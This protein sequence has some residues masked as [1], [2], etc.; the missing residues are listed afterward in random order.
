MGQ[1]QRES[2]ELSGTRIDAVLYS[3]RR[4]PYAMRARLALAISGTTC[5]LREVKL[6]AKPQAMLGASPKGTVPVVVLP[7]GKVID[8]SLDIMRW[9]LLHRDPEGWL[10]RDDPQWIAL[11]DGPFKHDLDRYK[12]PERYGSDS[13]AHRERGLD[14]LRAIDER[15]ADAGQLCGSARGLADAAIFPFVRQFAAVE[16]DWFAAQPLPHLQTW[17]AGHLA[18]D[19]FQKIMM[20]SGPWSPGDPPILFAQP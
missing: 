13:L 5:E 15:L 19:L 3:F 14:F 1:F 9:A 16:R 12:Y 20:H 8:E 7:D 17:L 2:P 10:K 11:N 4:C 18:S 6:S